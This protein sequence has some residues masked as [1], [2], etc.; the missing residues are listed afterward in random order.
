MSDYLVKLGANAAAR[1][2]LKTLN[3]PLPLPATLK[4]STDPWSDTPLAGKTFAV[5]PGP[6]L[7]LDEALERA[8]ASFSAEKPDLRI[9][10]ATELSGPDD[11]VRLHAALHAAPVARGGRLVVVGSPVEGTVAEQAARRAVEGFVRSYAREVGGRGIT[12]NLVIGRTLAD[13]EGPVTWLCTDYASFV[14]AQPLHTDGVSLWPGS[15]SMEA[16]V[17]VIT[18][19]A[20]G[21]GASCARAFAREGAKVVLVDI[22]AASEPLEALAEELG[23]VAVAADITGD[24]AVATLN[25]ALAPLGGADAF[26]HNAGITRDRTLKKMPE[27]RWESVI[28]VNLRAILALHDGLPVND[29]GSVVAMSSIAGI[30]GNFGQT[31]YGASKAGVIGFVRAAAENP[32]G[33]RVNAVAPGFI[34][35]QMTAAIPLGTREAGRRLSALVQGGQPEDVADAVVFLCSSAAAGMNGQ[36]LRVCGGGYLG[37]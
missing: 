20:R 9:V 24:D 15:R 2:V 19:A 14:D 25:A 6:M 31:N 37:A 12:V 28:S 7:G 13:V 18:G 32:R 17:V 27:E 23:G 5:S 22:P 1:T 3:L 4:R 33:V 8:G 29:G 21:I 16:E 11:L 10:D 35:T 26:V 30:S 36:V 34:E